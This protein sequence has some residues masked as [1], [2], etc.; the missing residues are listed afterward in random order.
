MCACACMEISNHA[1][2]HYSVGNIRESPRSSRA[3]DAMNSHFPWRA[4]L[5]TKLINVTKCVARERAHLS[6]QAQRPAFA[7]FDF[8][9]VFFFYI[10]KIYFARREKHELL[11]AK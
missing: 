7:A 9:R 10:E 2:C 1:V 6:S 4:D 8:A 3:I 5:T 11:R